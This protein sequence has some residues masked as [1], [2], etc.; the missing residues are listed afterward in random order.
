MSYAT[1][2]VDGSGNEVGGLAGSN[3]FGRIVASYA[4]SSVNGSENVGGLAGESHHSDIVGSYATGNVLGDQHAGGLVGAES[5]SI[6]ESAS[7]WDT[8][9]SGQETSAAGKGKTTGEL[10]SPT[11]YV[12]IYGVW[13]TDLDNADGDDDA[14]TEVDD[15]WDFG[16]SGQYPALKFDFDGNGEATW[17]EFGSQDR[18]APSAPMSESGIAPT[19]TATP[20]P[21]PLPTLTPAPIEATATPESV[22]TVGSGDVAPT[23]T[24]TAQT[25]PPA[26]SS[27]G[28][29]NIPNGDASTGTGAAS[30]LLLVAPLAIFGGLKY[31]RRRKQSRRGLALQA[32]V[33]FVEGLGH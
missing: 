30:A 33:H 19:P 21:I 5:G 25:S 31:R 1:G 17:Q 6:R 12:G 27:G 22:G 11:G 3:N 32:G 7:F 10:Q 15:F 18:D 9:T 24:P 13:A 4:T 14:A 2:S 23:A 8:Q 28:S 29:C 20:E 16:S 26:A